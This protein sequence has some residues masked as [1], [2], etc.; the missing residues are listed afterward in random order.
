M[1]TAV[2]YTAGEHYFGRN[3][4]LDR[5]CDESSRS[6]FRTDSEPHG[7]VFWHLAVSRQN[8]ILVLPF[9]KTKIGSG[10][11][12]AKSERRKCSLPCA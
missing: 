5:S 7:C 3:L 1:C 2:T 9:D 10:H 6:I 8:K 12:S 4:D 11:I